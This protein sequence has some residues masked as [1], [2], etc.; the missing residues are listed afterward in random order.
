[1]DVEDPFPGKCLKTKAYLADVRGFL[2]LAYDLATEISW[3]ISH[4]LFKVEPNFMNFSIAGESFELPD[5]LVSLAIRKKSAYESM[6][7]DNRQLYF[8][9]LASSKEGWVP[10]NVVN[11]APAFLANENAH[12]EKFQVIGDR[13]VYFRIIRKISITIENFR[14]SHS[15]AEAMDSNG[16]LFFGIWN[17]IGIAC[18]HYSMPYTPANIHIVAQNNETLQFPSGVKVIK[19]LYGQE[20][21]WVATMKLQVK[22]EYNLFFFRKI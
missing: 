10:I 13:Q 16:N 17:P 1:M 11:D 19:N 22:L 14:G 21:L 15:S 20:E 7:Y 18:W 9:S 12:A 4:D 6:F 3:K 5:G 2:I 8:H